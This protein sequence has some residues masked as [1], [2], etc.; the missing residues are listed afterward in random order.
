MGVPAAQPRAAGPPPPDGSLSVVAGG[1]GDWIGWLELKKGGGQRDGH[2]QH[3]ARGA[4]V[5]ADVLAVIEAED[6]PALVRYVLP[7]G[8]P[9][10]APGW[11]YRHVMLIEGTDERGID[12]GLMTRQWQPITRM[13]AT[14]T[15]ATATTR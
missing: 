13:R 12:V 15:T 8:W 10:G 1:R 9:D 11:R 14:S 5:G 7:L 3:R 2:P 6:R 4:D